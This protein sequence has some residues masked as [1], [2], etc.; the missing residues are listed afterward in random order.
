M[1][2]M[3]ERLAVKMKIKNSFYRDEIPKKWRLKMQNS[4]MTETNII[5]MLKMQLIREINSM[6]TKKERLSVAKL[7]RL[8]VHELDSLLDD[9]IYCDLEG[10]PDADW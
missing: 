6:G 7:R 3:S 1:F 10:D 9:R 5:S 2:L 8:S 4:T